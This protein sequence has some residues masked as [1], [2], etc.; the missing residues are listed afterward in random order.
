MMKKIKRLSVLIVAGFFIFAPPGTLILGAFLVLVLLRN[1]RI[2]VACAL[3]L[4]AL[5]TLCV[6]FRKKIVRW[7]GAK[8]KV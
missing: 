1:N 2:L 8:G 5:L 6:L 4:A 7:L 3:C